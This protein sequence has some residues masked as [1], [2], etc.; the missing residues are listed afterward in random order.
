L[1]QDLFD[2][3]LPWGT[4]NKMPGGEKDSQPT[5]AEGMGHALNG[6]TVV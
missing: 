4:R 6:R 1:L 5:I 3:L 2:G